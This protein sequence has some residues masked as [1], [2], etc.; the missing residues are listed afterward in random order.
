LLDH[1]DE[2][3]NL[4]NNWKNPCGDDIPAEKIVRIIQNNWLHTL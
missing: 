2:S 4:A 3:L 1:V